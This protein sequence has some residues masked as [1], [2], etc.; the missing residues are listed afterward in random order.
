M[1][2]GQGHI[3]HRPIWTS[4]GSATVDSIIP[5]I[6]QWLKECDESHTE[7]C[8]SQ[9]GL[10][11]PVLP[12]RVIDVG[13]SDGSRE[14][15]LFVPDG[16]CGRYTTLSHCWGKHLPLKTT[17]S[18]LRTRRHAIPFE[19]LPKTYRDAVSITRSLGIRYVWIDSLCIVQGKTTT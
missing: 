9:P 3:K 2:I 12:S 1:L 7:S 14:P 10:E 15:Y 16:C 6:L 17:M 19:T 11:L 18:T 4:S 13:E 5:T 8:P